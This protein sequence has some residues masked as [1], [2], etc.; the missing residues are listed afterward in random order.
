MLKTNRIV[1]DYLLPG[2]PEPTFIIERHDDRY[3]VSI[4]KY[5]DR[6]IDQ[7]I[8]L[9][10]V[11][12]DIYN[13]PVPTAIGRIGKINWPSMMLSTV[14]LSAQLIFIGRKAFRS[15]HN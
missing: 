9:H 15:C 13:P 4:L 7:N 11:G 10:P 5:S 12:G 14:L 6:Y 2:F 1:H 3:T 8:E